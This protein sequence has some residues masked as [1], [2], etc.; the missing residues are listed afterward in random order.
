MSVLNIP[1]ILIF[2]IN[3]PVERYPTRWIVETYVN[4][5]HYAAFKLTGVSVLSTRAQLFKRWINLYPVDSA[6]AT[7]NSYPLDS[8]LSGG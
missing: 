3:A 5:N 2:M 7:P 1:N 6:I 4:I 8:D